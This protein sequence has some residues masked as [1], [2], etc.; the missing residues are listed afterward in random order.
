MIDLKVCLKC[1]SSTWNSVI[2]SVG[3]AIPDNELEE[4]KCSALQLQLLG[5]YCVVLQFLL[6]GQSRGVSY[7]QLHGQEYEED[8]QRMI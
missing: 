2:F 7:V 3:D 5:L 8:C 6:E 4:Q 1:L